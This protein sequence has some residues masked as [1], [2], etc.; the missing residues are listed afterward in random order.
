MALSAMV[1]LQ[2]EFR[3]SSKAVASDLLGL[4]CKTSFKVPTAKILE[5]E[6]PRRVI[7]RAS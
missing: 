2:M 1:P 6:I 3:F 7:N 4:V 5:E